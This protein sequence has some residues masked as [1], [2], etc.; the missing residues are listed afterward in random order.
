MIF[1]MLICQLFGSPEKGIYTENWTQDSIQ[2]EVFE[3]FDALEKSIFQ[4]SDDSIKIINFWATW[5]KPCVKELPYFI[6]LADEYSDDKVQLVLVS[7]DDISRLH[8]KLIPFLKKNNIREKVVLLN[9]SKAHKWIDRVDPNWSG[10][11]PITLVMKG[12]ERYL[13]ERE[14]EDVEDVRSN[15][16]PIIKP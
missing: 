1:L 9:D 11:I 12:K 8:D 5:C 6:E 10:A 16:E 14:F 13:F 15:I 7:L 2:V 4:V 3:T